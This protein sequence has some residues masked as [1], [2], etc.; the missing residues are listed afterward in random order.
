MHGSRTITATQS[1]SFHELSAMTALLRGG[2]ALLMVLAFTLVLVWL[3]VLAGISTFEEQGG[4]Q[5]ELMPP[6]P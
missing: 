3:Q 4:Y 2:S 5:T 1:D 6:Y